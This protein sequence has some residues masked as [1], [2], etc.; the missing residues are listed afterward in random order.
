MTYL[1]KFDSYLCSIY[2]LHLFVF[3]VS[4][5]PTKFI[6]RDF[7]YSIFE[8][9]GNETFF[10]IVPKNKINKKIFE[11]NA[12]PPHP[13]PHV[14]RKSKPCLEAVKA[15]ETTAIVHMMIIWISGPCMN[16]YPC[17]KRLPEREEALSKPR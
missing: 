14:N 1:I 4:F 7:L 10:Y 8:R 5:L 15:S 13:C 16:K 3:M 2:I 6:R 12:R 9:L 11:R 17:E